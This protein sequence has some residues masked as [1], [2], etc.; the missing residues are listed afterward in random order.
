MV[1]F[2]LETKYY[3]QTNCNAGA[4][5]AVIPANGQRLQSV[6]ILKMCFNSHS[7]SS[8]NVQALMKIAD[9]YRLN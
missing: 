6:E 7:G 8:D 1:R 5:T 4:L 3:D 9:R 2:R